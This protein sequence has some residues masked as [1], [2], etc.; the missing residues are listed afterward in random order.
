MLADVV[1]SASRQDH[2]YLSHPAFLCGVP[3]PAYSRQWSAQL[4]AQNYPDG[5]PFARADGIF[6]GFGRYQWLPERNTFIE[7]LMN[8]CPGHALSLV[9]S[10]DDYFRLPITDRLKA[11]T[12]HK[13][14]LTVPLSDVSTRVFE[15]L[16][17]GQIPLV[18][19]DVSDLNLIVPADVQR[20]LPILRYRRGSIE[21]VQAAWRDGV[22]RFDS[23]GAVGIARRHAFARDHHSLT[24]RIRSFA[25]FLRKPGRNALRREGRIVSWVEPGTPT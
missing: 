20:V 24:A 15:A 16:M 5:L 17:T 1:F 9:N 7:Q 21:S 25:A 3:M 13:A 12:K 11:W 4:I 2:D 10:V 19:D 18:P 6:G 22:V 23:E 14:H 8:Q